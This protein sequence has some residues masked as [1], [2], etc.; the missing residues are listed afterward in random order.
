MSDDAPNPLEAATTAELVAELKR[1]H[2]AVLVVTLRT[3][4]HDEGEICCLF[5]EG[6]ITTCIGLAARARAVLVREANS[7]M[8]E[9]DPDDLDG[10]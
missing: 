9:Q 4:D 7:K 10:G 1:R 6:S 2:G 3:D 5:N 8:R